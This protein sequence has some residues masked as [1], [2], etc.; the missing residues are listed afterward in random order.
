M[1]QSIDCGLQGGK[2]EHGADNMPRLHIPHETLSGEALPQMQMVNDL[3]G[4]APNVPAY[5][6]GLPD[7]MFAFE[8]QDTGDKLIRVAVHV[9]RYALCE[10]EQILNRGAAIM[11]VLNQLSLEGYSIELWAIWRNKAHGGT[12]SIETCIKHG[13]DHWT[14][15]SV[16]FALCHAAFQR[17]L[18]W[19]AAES[20]TGKGGRVT[21]H[22]YGNG[23]DADFS[24][25][26]ISF[27]YVDNV[28]D[29]A[30]T[31]PASAVEYIKESTIQQL[32]TRG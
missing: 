2:W 21:N 28:I 13:T 18:C 29:N 12:V 11:A 3:Q 8:E 9:G 14:P 20:L 22:G 23:K 16:A 4:F 26:D 1:E 17:R 7:D 6:S 5:L 19:R 27:P 30:I 24:D 15:S 31:T 25:Y 10:Q 32:K